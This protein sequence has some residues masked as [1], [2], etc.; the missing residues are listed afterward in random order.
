M[1]FFTGISD[2]QASSSPSLT[3]V[4]EESVLNPPITLLA[5][6]LVNGSLYPAV[7]IDQA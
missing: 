7:P 3:P 5:K 1:A 4:Q 2:R 6:N